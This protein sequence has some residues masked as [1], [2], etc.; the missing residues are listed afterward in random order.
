MAIS[1]ELEA[2]ILRLYHV[3]G[4]RRGTISRMLRV[5]HATV[6]RILA[7][8][9]LLP[10][11]VSGRRSRVDPYM[12][13]ILST[14]ERFPKLNASRLYQMVKQRGYTGGPDY[15]RHFIA[16]VRPV[17]SGEAFLRLS[18]LPGEQA[19]A[20]W[21]CFGKIKIGNAERRLLA[22]VMV[23]SWSRFIFLRF[24]LGDATGNF[25]RGHIDAFEHFQRVPREILYDNLK[26][27][28]IERIDT[29]IRFN[30][31]LINLATHY[32]F[33]PKPVAVRRANEKG[34]VERAI[35]YV[36]TAFF[37]ARQFSDIED[38]NQQ[39]IQWCLQ[40]ARERPCPG[41]KS[42]TVWEAFEQERDS[43]LQLPSVPYPVYDRKPVQT[44]KTPFIRFDLND[45]SVPHEFV[46]RTLL[47]EATLQTVNIVD[48]ITI[49]ATHP[50]SFDKGKQIEDPQHFE[51]LA[52]EKRHASRQR[53]MNRILA[54][55][56]SSKTF[57]KIA[58]QRGHNM[59]RLTQ[60]L[61]YLL[62]LYGGSELERALCVAL[63]KGSIH[64]SAVQYE[65]EARR[66]SKGL[67]LPI[68]LRFLKDKRVDE[69]TIIPKTL[70]TY[71]KLI[72]KEDLE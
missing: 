20:D 3:E 12:P 65:L 61:I 55:A 38:L 34:R 50:R 44:G 14:L 26:S 67:P 21:A 29:A 22:F 49:V 9:G 56:P 58:A 23:L 60:A 53:G 32:R 1:K 69:I 6:D 46:R 63:A 35:R 19:Q 8:N 45:Y 31:E 71:D 68:P 2:E 42:L 72:N 52:R 59:G 18:T 47:V 16:R 33:G 30:P 7:K 37:A 41:N 15:F 11:P 66:A 25:L 43:L 64:T 36:R 4:W 13:F 40:E 17:R 51:N 62:D 28:V 5:H 70:D 10:M 39:A 54:I 27:A 57:F 48:G 24:Y